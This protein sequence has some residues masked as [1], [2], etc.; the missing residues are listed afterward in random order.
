METE[1]DHQPTQETG[2]KN[3]EINRIERHRLIAHLGRVFARN[4]DL[5]VLPSG[6]RGV[7][8]CG[9]DP[10]I[11]PAI[12]QYIEGKRETLDDLPPESFVPRQIFY[13][14]QAAQKMAMEQITTLLRH[15]AGHARYT[16]F[17]L[18]YQG[19]RAAKDEGHLPTSFWLTFEGI[20]DPRV[21]AL[22]GEES[23]AIDRLIRSNQ[24]GELHDRITESP[25]SD[26]PLMLQFA[27]NSFHYWLHGEGIPELQGTEVGR[28]GE[29]ARPLLEQYF[30]NT[31]V[32]QRG[33]LQK[34]IWDIAKE[35]EKKDLDQEEMRQMA[36][37]QK[38]Q[39]ERG[40]S[41]NPPEGQGPE[42]QEP[43]PSSIPA[44][45]KGFLD[46]LK[47]TLF[48]KKKTPLPPDPDK[49]SQE[50]STPEQLQG[51]ESSQPKPG[52]VDLTKLLPDEFKSIKDAIEQL[53][54]AER[55]VLGKMAKQTIDE[56]QKKVLEKRL[57]K[58][59]KL[60]KN[61]KT[62]EYEVIPQM[63]TEKEQQQAQADLQR[64][65]QQVGAEEQAEWDRQEA[66]RKQQEQ[67]LQQ[68]EAER[69]EKLEMAKAGF[70]PKDR[71]KYLL[72]QALEDSMYSSVRNFRQAIEK[73]IP[74]RKEPVHESGFFS[75]PR[76][77]R[78]DLIRKV[79]IGDERFH[80]RPVE[81][82]VGEPRLY[83]ALLVDN[84][85][86]MM[87]KK[88][89]EARKT[90]VFFARV[91]K[92]M[93][94]P[95]M[96]AAFGDHPDRIKSFRQDFDNP[97]ER[98]K[99]HIIDATD[100]SG[101][102]TDMHAGIEVTI[103]AMNEQRRRLSDSH[104][105]IF[106]ITDGGANTGLTGNALRNYIEEHRGRLTFKAFGLSGSESE[107]T[108]IR[109]YLNNY[110]GESNCAYPEGFEDLPDEAF[111]VLRVNLIQFQKYFA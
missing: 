65:I 87:G 46:R 1:L 43:V 102:S 111:K 17:R 50:A 97:A 68:I 19:Q 27:Y 70:D 109:G 13:D 81:R 82:P 2:K 79:P 54:P 30:Q 95:F 57:S 60:Q 88:M 61:K 101:I 86:S 32:K 39:Q 84:S 71:E 15:E 29:L 3:P 107:R 72:Y 45:Q 49:E 94:I 42:G 16:D 47:E 76:F 67:I 99:P 6:Q 40:E 8:S 75:G 105:L 37:R 28:L 110:F 78:R 35:L 7:W 4:Y 20:E 24:A 22:E 26:K 56:A 5:Q 58:T 59:M 108:T 53:S 25:L 38:D 69:R 21:N 36:Q 66:E 89:E 90:M 51:Q 63:A 103:E 93:G 77:D 9:L 104:G 55:E 62:G 34:Q 83:I 98:I 64:S 91:C 44:G 73:V 100:A 52:R 11:T 96:S 85:G 92:E 106:V 48:G 12:T 18:M 80:M 23:P 41:S 14:E 33:I 10:N 31:D 74:R